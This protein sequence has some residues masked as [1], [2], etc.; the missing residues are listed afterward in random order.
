VTEPV[1]SD[2]PIHL[3]ALRI[4]PGEPARLADR[5]TLDPDGVEG[6]KSTGKHEVLPERRDRIRRRQRRLYAEGRRSVLLILQGTDTSGKDGAIRHV[7]RGISPSGTRVASF[8]V[9]GPTELAQDYL[10]R[11]HAECPARGQ[12]GVFNRSHYEDVMA[13]RVRG[14]VEEETWR[15]RYRHIREFERLLHD[16]G[17]LVLK[18]FLHLSRAAQLERLQSRLDDPEK[19]WKFSQGDIEDRAL[20]PEYQVAY[21]E[22]LTE[23]STPWAPWY[24]VPA[25]R[26]WQRNLVVAELLEAA[27]AQLD[28]Q[29]PVRDDL[30]DVVIG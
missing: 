23:T 17:T 29:V 22:A 11:I 7:L 30:D 14:I 12:I 2:L 4:D 28:P 26:K 3:A 13:V 9:P 24:V 25:D 6:D 16:E 5:P 21:E 20:W 27:L 10:W 18:C 15:P 8:G 1:L 19:R